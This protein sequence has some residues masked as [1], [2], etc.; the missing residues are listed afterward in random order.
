MEIQ[1]GAILLQ[2]LNFGVVAGAL[3]FLLI[4]PLR[5]VLDERSRQ[6]AEG[7]Q[8]AAEAVAN[9]E[10]SEKDKSKVIAQAQ[11]EAKQIL[12]EARKDAE[13]RSQEII[14]EADKKAKA[15]LQRAKIQAETQKTA[16]MQNL[17]EQ[18]NQAVALIAKQVIGKE[19]T[20]KKH[21]DLIK[22]GLN[23]IKKSA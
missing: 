22:K 19:L 7:Q 12:D 5:K 15:T 6:L 11:K 13:V 21:E 14:D 8:A 10:Q 2:I 16:A 1:V 17:Q 20:A 4:K 3:T 18:F 23:Q 9:Q